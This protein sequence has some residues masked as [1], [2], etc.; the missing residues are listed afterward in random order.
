M[1]HVKR[2][3][4]VEIVLKLTAG[5]LRR[6]IPI[7]DELAVGVKER[8]G[9]ETGGQDIGI[10]LGDLVKSRAETEVLLNEPLD[11]RVEGQPIGGALILAAARNRQQTV[12]ANLRERQDGWR[13]DPLLARVR[14]PPLDPAV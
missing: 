12:R 11:R 8:V 13:G 2:I 1:G 14:R 10:G 3:G 5:A 4:N 6:V 7:R 9:P